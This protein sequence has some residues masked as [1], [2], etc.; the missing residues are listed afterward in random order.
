MVTRLGLLRDLLLCSDDIITLHVSLIGLVR[1]LAVF[2]CV[3]KSLSSSL[4][5]TAYVIRPVA[6]A[7]GV[8]RLS[9]RGATRGAKRRLSSPR[10]L[11][12]ERGI[13]C[14]DLAHVP[15]SISERVA[16]E[17]QKELKEDTEAYGVKPR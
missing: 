5:F 6:A 12:L 11:C 16:G 14:H 13:W 9:P 8:K 10:R 2:W 17:K 1:Y 4:F 7:M 3:I 15:V